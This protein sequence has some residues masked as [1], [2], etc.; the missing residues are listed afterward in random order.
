MAQDLIERFATFR[1]LIQLAFAVLSLGIGI[2][3]AQPPTT[4]GSSQG[5]NQSNW[6]GG[7]GG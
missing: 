5:G 2:A 4:G 1:T 3:H 6:L 7:G